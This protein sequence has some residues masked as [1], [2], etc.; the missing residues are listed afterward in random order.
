MATDSV[1]GLF[2]MQSPQQLQQDYLSG[3]MVS[4]AQMGQQGLLQQLISTGANAGAMMGYGG[5]RLLGGKVAGEVEAAQIEDTL[6]QVNKMNLPSTYEKMQA[7]SSLLA[8]KG[9]TKQAMIAGAEA[10]KL[11]PKDESMSL[12]K[13][14]TAESVAKFRETKDVKDLVRYTKEDKTKISAYAQQLIDQGLKLGTPE[15]NTAMEAYNKAEIAGKAPKPEAKSTFEKQMDLAGI[16]DPAKRQAMATR[17]LELDLRADKGDPTAKAALDLMAKQID[18]QIAQLK[19]EKAKDEKTAAEKAEVQSASA[20]AYKTNNILNTI[21]TA[22][23]QVGGSTAGLGG[24]VMRNLP[25]SE[26]VDLEENLLTIKANI[27]FNELT[28]MRKDSPTGGA[29]GQVSDMENKALQAARASLEQRQSPDQLRTNLNKI[30]D[31]YD[32]WLKVITGE[33]TEADAQAYLDSLKG[34][35]KG[36]G[37]PVPNAED[38][39]LIN[40]YLKVK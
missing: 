15:F 1:S 6:Q 4:P 39:A 40:K 25:G 21:D 29:L 11:K 23:G 27:G 2:G 28:Q 24:A 38:S 19:L 26:A 8:E 17:K 18:I 9:L 16:T 12:L 32:R 13:D 10:E 3:L 35:E 31:S 22:I 34:E 33:W 7:M 14:F 5:G 20:E 37:K 30:K 36:Q